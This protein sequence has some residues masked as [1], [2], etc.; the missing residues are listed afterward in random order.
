MYSNTV[1]PIPLANLT[2]MISRRDARQAVG[3]PANQVVLLSVG[4]AEKYRPCGPYDFV[5]T[6]NN[7]LDRHPSTHLYVIGE[8]QDGIAPYLRRTIHERMHFMGSIEDPSLYR[9]AA[10]IYLESFPFGS[11]TALLE[12]A[13]SGLPVVPAYAPL[14]PLLV[15]GNDAT[16][17]LL[18]NPEREQEYIDRVGLLIQKPDQRAELGTRLRERLMVD[19]VGE[20]WLNWLAA[21]YQRTDLMTHRPQAVPVSTCITTDADIGL[22]IWNAM[23]DGTYKIAFE[24]HVESSL[25]H[26]AFAAKEAG[27][28][29]KARRFAWRALLHNPYRGAFWR[30]FA[31]AVLGKTLSAIRPL[32]GRA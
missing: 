8:S 3:I 16:Q 11:N 32:V 20:G 15:A 27:D 28:Y 2:E 7:I 4:R 9:S 22:S 19:H 24:D 26:T 31:V 10:D 12:A 14:S 1:L 30:L 13:L 21:L 17:D 18:L 29:A 25:S 6:A 5:S 23:S